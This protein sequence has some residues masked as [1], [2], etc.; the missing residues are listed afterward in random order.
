MRANRR[1]SIVGPVLLVAVGV[2]LL[3]LELGDLQ[4]SF[5]L[6]WLATWWPIVLVGAGL[7]LL[8]EWILDT[9]KAGQYG[10]GLPRRSLGASGVLVLLVLVLAGPA[11]SGVYRGS[12]WARDHWRLPEAWG[13]EEMLAQHSETVVDL[14]A[15]LSRGG[16][17]TVQNYRGN[18]TV[19]GSSQDGR[20]HVSAHQRLWA[21]QE[22]DLQSLQRRDRPV[23]DAEGTGLHLKV[24]GDGRDQTDLVIEMPHDAGVQIDPEKGEVAVSELR[25]AVAIADH[26]GNVVLTALNGDVHLT[27]HDD[28][29]GISGHSLSGNLT[30]EGR[31]G[32]ISLSDVSGP[33][34]LRGDFFGTTHLEHVSG[35]VHF[36]SSFTEFTCAGIPGDLDIEGRSEL[37]AHTID[38]PVTLTTTDR[39]ITL[40]GIRNGVAVTNQKGSVTLSFLDLTAPVTVATT[41]GTIEMQVPEKAPF[42][43]T[44]E[45]ADGQIDNDLGLQ[46]QKHE[47]RMTLTGQVRSGGPAVQLKTSEGDIKLRK[48]DLSAPEATA[49]NSKDD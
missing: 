8:G 23:L 28:D 27:V 13:L 15:P 37:R 5:A 36:Q 16:L 1:V 20:V 11:V 10:T 14:D 18:I 43:V 6:A 30:L 41:D 24:E 46:T 19:T 25:G 47:D 39:D 26:A 34:A 40:S 35:P 9:R 48:G 4:W 12:D 42:H 49:E 32:D 21:W 3:L 31:S 7:V 22:R 29:A 44:A 38:G 17:L 33:V 2:V 45:T